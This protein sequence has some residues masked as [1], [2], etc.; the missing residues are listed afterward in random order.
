MGKRLLLLSAVLLAISARASSED[1]GTCPPTPPLPKPETVH[2][3]SALH[4]SPGT[5]IPDAKYAGTV[6][7]LTE[8]SDKGN[9]CG[10]RLIRGF[11]KIA[12]AQAMLKVR[13]WRFNP[14]QKGGRP[15]PVV[16][17][18]AIPFWRD[19]KGQLFLGT[20]GNPVR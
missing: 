19:A 4:G 1:K 18:L 17:T 9:V 10:A 14:A 5:P 13:Q 8:I 2:P 11:D 7:L 16:I 20:H 15:V 6:Y 12:D 3:E